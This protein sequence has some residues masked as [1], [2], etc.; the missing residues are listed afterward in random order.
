MQKVNSL[1]TDSRPLRAEYCIVAFHAIQRFSYWYR[2]KIVVHQLYVISAIAT[3][4]NS[5][6]SNRMALSFD[7]QK[8]VLLQLRQKTNTFCPFWIQKCSGLHDY[9]SEMSELKNSPGSHYGIKL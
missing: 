1:C 4:S 3:L 9:N 2:H 8:V 6:V 5:A 7:E